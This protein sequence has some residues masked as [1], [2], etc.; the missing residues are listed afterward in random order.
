MKRIIAL[1]LSVIMIFSVVPFSVSAADENVARM[2]ICAETNDITGIRHIFLY[3]E[4]LTDE[5]IRVGRYDLAAYDEVSVGCVGTE[6]PRG[7]GVYYNLETVLDHY[8]NQLA[9]STE[10]DEGELED[11]T[12][13]IKNYNRWD[14]IFNCYYFAAK[15]WNAGADK[16]VPFLIFPGFASIFIKM[17]GGKSAPFDIFAEEKP[18][19]KQN[20][21]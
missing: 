4:N 18:V 15:G 16:S 21:L 8:S 6:G 13:A 2:W 3:F 1:L 17:K 7:G 19:Y 11:V 9:L 5:T 10:L 12:D 20:E 14:P